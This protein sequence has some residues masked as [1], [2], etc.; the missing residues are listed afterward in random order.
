VHRVNCPTA[1]DVM[2]ALTRRT[3]QPHAL[4]RLAAGDALTQSDA[5]WR[6]VL[7]GSLLTQAC[8]LAGPVDSN[9]TPIHRDPHCLERV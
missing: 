8:N 2:S 6:H 3:R 7:H 9:P 1:S 5:I 4:L